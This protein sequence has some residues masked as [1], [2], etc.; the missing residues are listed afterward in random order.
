MTVNGVRTPGKFSWARAQC[1]LLVTIAFALIGCGPRGHPPPTT[2]TPSP[3]AIQAWF[4]GPTGL[5]AMTWTGETGPFLA[6]TGLNPSPDGSRLLRQTDGRVF[7]SR[8]ARIGVVPVGRSMIWADDSRTVCLIAEKSVGGAEVDVVDVSTGTVRAV[9][10]E[11]DVHGL[12]LATCSPSAG[13]IILTRGQPFHDPHDNY[14]IVTTSV[15]VIELTTGKTIQDWS[16]QPQAKTAAITSHDGR[17]LAEVTPV[18]TTVRDLS[19]NT[20]AAL[21]GQQVWAFSWDGTRVATWST[22]GAAIVDLA[23]GQAIWTN[24]GALEGVLPAP[25]GRDFLVTV[26]AGSGHAGESVDESYFVGDGTKRRLPGRPVQ[27]CPCY[28]LGV[29]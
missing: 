25:Q 22:R 4:S 14:R 11:S 26:V 29:A 5:Q 7:D 2:P 18:G 24:H 28:L 8:G 1:L 12:S 9:R 13:I 15:A 27:Y 21:P 17:L 19:R 16:Y 10:S 6:M 3:D 20:V 23:S